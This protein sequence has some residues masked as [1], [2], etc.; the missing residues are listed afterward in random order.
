MVLVL[1]PYSPILATPS[2]A[3]SH[4]SHANESVLKPG[5]SY[6]DVVQ[7]RSK[8]TQPGAGTHSASTS[9][10][11]ASP[12]DRVP[13]GDITNN[14]I[15][16]NPFVSTD[17]SSNESNDENEPWTAV[18][19]RRRKTENPKPKSKGR[20][21]VKKD[22]VREAKKLL[23]N[24][25][26]QHILNWKPAEERAQSLEPYPASLG[27]GPSK[28]KN[29]DPRNWGNTD[30]DES[31]IDIE[32]QREAIET[33]ARLHDWAKDMPIQDE[34]SEEES[35]TIKNPAQDALNKKLEKR[36]SPDHWVPLKGGK[37][38]T[39]I[40][41]VK[42]MVERTVKKS[43]Q[44]R[45]S[46]ATPPAVDAAAQIARESYLGQA[47][48]KMSGK[49]GRHAAITT[50]DSPSDSSGPNDSSASSPPSSSESESS[51]SDSDRDVARTKHASKK[52]SKHKKKH[53]SSK[54]RATLKPVPPSE[55]DG[56]ADS[57]AFHRFMT[58]GKAYLEDGN[59]SKSNQVQV[60]AR[61]LKGKAHDFYTR[62]VSDRPKEWRLSKFL[63]ELFNYC[64]PL[65]FQ[66][67]QRKKLYRCY[68]GD[69]R[70]WF[71][72]NMTI[73]NELYKMHLN[74]EVSSLWKVQNTTEIIELAHLASSEGRR[75]DDDPKPEKG[76]HK[77][78]KGRSKVM[79]GAP[80]KNEPNGGPHNKLNDKPLGVPNY[81]M[82][83]ETGKED[84]QALK[85]STEAITEIPLSC[86]ML[87]EMSTQKPVARIW[88]VLDK[89][90]GDPVTRRAEICHP[91]A[92]IYEIHDRELSFLIEAD[93]S[94]LCNEKL[95]IAHWYT[96]HLLKG[97]Q[98]LNALMLSKELEWEDNHFWLLDAGNLSPLDCMLEEVIHQ[99]Y[100]IPDM[101]FEETTHHIH[102]ME[103]ND[104]QVAP[105]QYPAL[106]WNL[107]ITCDFKR[108]IL[109]PVVV[110]SPN[111]HWLI[112]GLYVDNSG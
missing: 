104:Q 9:S 108:L 84:Y 81:V 72:L 49:K 1:A 65:D 79:D 26:K 91:D 58:E 71:G 33:W 89:P 96:K 97:Y 19:S 112:G 90:I 34:D 52:C 105:G 87:G 48:N 14:I 47:F 40:D 57:H 101:R 94:F 45:E 75:R 63:T 7:T 62:Q 55:Y 28:G 30:L 2:S 17:E 59:V 61:H 46:R 77:T 15:N 51:L 39:T 50:D 53:S 98:K 99:I 44:R 66:S 23:T 67:R 27:E 5:R 18:K 32:A 73:Q 41:P 38:K 10:A 35:E 36:T 21:A 54:R 85:D 25:E 20:S 76:A 43:T 29:V 31:E 95:N 6:S 60:L 100:A 56:S 13:L 8:T 80:E 88:G 37:S 110:V 42:D 92:T 83:V 106:Q 64:F 102:L 24:K 93:E 107:A 12:L 3:E 68:Q 16:E 74:P 11:T 82:H 4:N 86:M 103:L 78:N 69:K 22:L 109:K 70:F 111:R